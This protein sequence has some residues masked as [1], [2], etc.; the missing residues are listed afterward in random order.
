[1]S[2]IADRIHLPEAGMEAKL[3]TGPKLP[4]AGP[5]F[6]RLEILA[7]IAETGSIPRVDSSAAPITHPAGSLIF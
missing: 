2:I 6:P 4:I 3:S 5:I 7:E 1:M